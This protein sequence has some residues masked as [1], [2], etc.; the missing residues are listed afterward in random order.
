MPSFMFD[1]LITASFGKKLYHSCY[2]GKNYQHIYG[3][4]VV[5]E[6]VLELSSPFGIYSYVVSVFSVCGH[7]ATD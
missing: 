3:N 7:K 2:H 1:L 5:I 6:F 4:I